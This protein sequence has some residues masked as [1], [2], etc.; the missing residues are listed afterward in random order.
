LEAELSGASVAGEAI[1]TWSEEPLEAGRPPLTDEDRIRRVGWLV[2][3]RTTASDDDPLTWWLPIRPA[4]RTFDTSCGNLL[5]RASLAA[6]ALQA[7]GIPGEAALIPA[8]P[9]VVH[10]VPSLVQF[11]DLWWFCPTRVLSARDG[12]VASALAGGL[13]EEIV[14]MKDGQTRIVPLAPLRAS[15]SITIRLVEE[16]DGTIRGHAAVRM[17]GVVCRG[18]TSGSLQESLNGMV[19]DWVAGAEVV[20]SEVETM[21]TDTLAIVLSLIGESIGEP[22]GLGRRRFTVPSAPGIDGSSLPSPGLLR[23]MSRQTPLVLPMS[24]DERVELR[25]EPCDATE[26]LLT[27]RD[28]Q[29]DARGASLVRAVRSRDGGWEFSRHLR[30]DDREVDPEEYPAFREL[31][32]ERLAAPGNDLYFARRGGSD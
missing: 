26:I 25:F 30:V 11:T 20:G 19:A 1:R 32:L 5:D 29:I 12:E 2:G 18:Y 31:L 3:E 6:A 28:L 14:R 24:V 17:G 22:A 10:E 4:E 13:A 21:T 16:G 23:R 7:F 9:R 27:P 15:S 8:G